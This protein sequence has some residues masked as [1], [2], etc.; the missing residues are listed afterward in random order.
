MGPEHIKPHRVTKPMQLLAA[1]LVGL[2]L[3]NGAFLMT[4]S[5][6]GVGQWERSALVIAAIANVPVF[7]AAIFVLQTRFRAEL[8]EDT[9][10]SEYLSK[11]TP[12]PVTVSGLVRGLT[13]AGGV[14]APAYP[15]ASLAPIGR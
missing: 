13:S 6:F 8:Q 14:W 9:F 11:N 15:A 2:L 4:A 3:T 1:W 12:N 7:L 10:H 5:G